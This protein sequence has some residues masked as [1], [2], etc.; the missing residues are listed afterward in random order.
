[1]V[2]VA[3]LIASLVKGSSVRFA[4]PFHVAWKIA[5]ITTIR[6]T[7]V[8]KMKSSKKIPEVILGYSGLVF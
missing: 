2:L 7:N 8:L 4:R 1:M 6:N 5:A 3:V